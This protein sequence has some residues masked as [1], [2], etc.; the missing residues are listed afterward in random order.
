MG[1][2]AGTVRYKLVTVVAAEVY[3]SDAETVL[4]NKAETVDSGESSAPVKT[5]EWAAC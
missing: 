4:W 1:P 2:E 5:F 3:R